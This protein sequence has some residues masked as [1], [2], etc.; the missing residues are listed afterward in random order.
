[1]ID[2]QRTEMRRA[3][4]AYL[5]F[6]FSV[7]PVGSDK[8][9]LIP[10]WKPYQ[11]RHATHDEVEAWFRQ[12]P[13]M[14][15]AIVTGKISGIVVIDVES[16][17]NPDAFPATAFASTGSGGWHLYYKHPGE[18]VT[19]S[20]RFAPDTDLRGDGGY[21]VAP[22]SY[23][24]ALADVSDSSKRHTQP[25]AWQKTPWEAGMTEYPKEFVNAQTPQSTEMTV[26]NAGA[27]VP[28][29]QRNDAAT[30]YIGRV[31]ASLPPDLWDVVGIG[32]L[33]EWNAQCVAE[34]LED[35]EL[36]AIFDSIRSAEMRSRLE[37]ATDTLKPITL[38]E[39]YREP[40]PEVPWLVQDL[41]PFGGVTAMTGDSNTFKTFLTST[42]AGSVAHGEP[43][44]GHF[45]TQ[46]GKVLIIDEENHRLYILRKRFTEM[47]IPETE[48][49]QVLSQQNLK[50]DTEKDVRALRALLDQE[51]PILVILDALV[52]FHSKEENSSTEMAKVMGAIR[53]LTADDRAVVLIHHHKKEQQGFK[54]KGGSQS[55]R[56]SSDIF[57]SLDC[58]LSIDR[59][60]YETT[61]TITQG[62]LRVQEQ[63]APFIAS[64]V[65]IDTEHKS[66]V[67]KGEDTTKADRVAE[68]ADE[69]KDLLANSDEAL[70]FKTIREHVDAKKALIAAAIALL[71]AKTEIRHRVGPRNTFFYYLKGSDEELPN[72][73]DEADEDTGEPEKTAEELP[74]MEQEPNNPP[75][76]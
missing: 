44:L 9:P 68:I 45:S 39:L 61:V 7:F 58:H 62:K 64:L 29:G 34:P 36:R 43:Y 75:P 74:P 33:R 23:M 12:W 18:T 25:Y 57:A 41:I 65:P 4:H 51:R 72:E 63:M 47:G 46:K 31:L 13:D 16:K 69:I 37:P 76:F 24:S 19:N 11:E 1:M 17:G 73:A 5:K 66:F 21:V 30:R 22:P 32:A 52:R 40:M 49:I 8:R 28:V 55:L 27:L 48:D 67:Y 54:R 15:I 60:A 26:R 42:L 6:G 14:N 56:G 2:E 35:K 71:E 10:S 38:S 3:A 20:T 70:T 50:L 53:S 59:K